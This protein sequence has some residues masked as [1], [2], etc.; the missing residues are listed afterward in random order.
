MSSTEKN[1]K[2]T[3][4]LSLLLNF[5]NYVSEAIHFS[6]E[7]SSIFNTEAEKINVFYVRTRVQGYFVLKL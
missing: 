2:D 3:C 7:V 1:S 5:G 6:L 4:T